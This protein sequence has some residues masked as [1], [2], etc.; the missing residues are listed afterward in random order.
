[1]IN[2]YFFIIFIINFYQLVEALRRVPAQQLALG[3]NFDGFMTAGWRMPI[4]PRIDGHFFPRPLADLR[5]EAPAKPMLVGICEHE[6]LLI[7]TLLF[8]FLCYF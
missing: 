6:G 8:C 1:V 2:N 5:A 4:G 7:R 3:L